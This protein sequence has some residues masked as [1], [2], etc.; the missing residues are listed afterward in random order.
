VNAPDTGADSGH[1]ADGRVGR[2]P[3]ARQLAEEQ[4]ALRRV[5]TLVARGAAPEEV[6]A[7]VV[8]E[9]GRLLPVDMAG[10]ARYDP[11]GTL[12]YV[13]SWGKTADGTPAGS[14]WDGQG[15][16]IATVVFDTGRSGRVE[17]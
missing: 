2:D 10:M 6:F 7:A 1:A 5:A 11:D 16:N 9:V 3:V 12:T 14:Q 4:A 15:Q 17:N 13:A 8:E